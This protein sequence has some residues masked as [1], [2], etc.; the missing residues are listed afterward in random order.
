MPLKGVSGAEGVKA[1]DEA[2]K[3]FL[4]A[5]ARVSQNLYAKSTIEGRFLCLRHAK[6]QKG[7][8]ASQSIFAKFPEISCDT[9]LKSFL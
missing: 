6:K 9:N 8:N 5:L 2:F 1:W 7:E 3:R 4:R